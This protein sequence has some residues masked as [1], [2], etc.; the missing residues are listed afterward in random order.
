MRG[1][2][3]R[4]FEHENRFTVR[5]RDIEWERV[6]LFGMPRVLLTMQQQLGV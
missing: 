6:L 5:K 3:K 4:L 2:G 1:A